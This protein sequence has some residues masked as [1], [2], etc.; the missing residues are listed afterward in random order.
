MQLAI[1]KRALESGRVMHDLV[2]TR[3]ASADCEAEITHLRVT[4]QKICGM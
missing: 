2:N 1:G 3:R 4:T